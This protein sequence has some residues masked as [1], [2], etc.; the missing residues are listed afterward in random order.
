MLSLWNHQFAYYK[1]SFE[2]GKMTKCDCIKQK[3]TEGTE[4]PGFHLFFPKKFRQQ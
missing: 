4:N 1:T 2:R 3:D